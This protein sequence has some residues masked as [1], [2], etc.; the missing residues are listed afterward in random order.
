MAN[1]FKKHFFF[2]LSGKSNLCKISSNKLQVSF[3]TP[4]RIYWGDAQHWYVPFI[5]SFPLNLE[6]FEENSYYLAAFHVPSKGW[7]KHF[8]AIRFKQILKKPKD[9]WKGFKQMFQINSQEGFWNSLKCSFYIF[10]K[11]SEMLSFEF[12]YSTI[13]QNRCKKNG[14]KSA[15]SGWDESSDGIGI[16]QASTGK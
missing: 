2:I 10:S 14:S 9:L 8:C 15:I 13:S 1:K 6:A 16:G 7:Q 5:Y 4:L 3:E 12:P 11:I